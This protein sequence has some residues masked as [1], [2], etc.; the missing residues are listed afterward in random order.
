[1]LSYEML[2]SKE[3]CPTIF[4]LQASL[5]LEVEV[6]QCTMDMCANFLSCLGCSK[7]AYDRYG[8][9]I[10]FLRKPIV[11][12]ELRVEVRR[13]CLVVVYA[14]EAE[15]EG[16]WASHSLYRRLHAWRK[17]NSSCCSAEDSQD[18]FQLVAR[19]ADTSFRELITSQR[20]VR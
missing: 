20:E 5:I 6:R 4:R 11:S 7:D 2:S 14:I 9:S 18:P 17:G 16:K 10:L 13:R 19:E 8:R 15:T 12:I 1:M 3:L